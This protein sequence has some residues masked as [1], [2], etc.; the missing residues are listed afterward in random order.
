M[1][2]RIEGLP[3]LRAA[4]LRISGEGEKTTKRAV[5]WGLVEIESTAKRNLTSGPYRAI[6]YGH[7][8]NSQTHQVDPDGLGGVAGTNL[9]YAPHVHFGTRFMRARPWLFAAAEEV[10]PKFYARLRR[11]LG[12]AFVRVTD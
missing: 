6:Q 9:D 12:Q 11:E 4:L 7:L 5:K 10:R 3:R 1:S 2:V 8:R